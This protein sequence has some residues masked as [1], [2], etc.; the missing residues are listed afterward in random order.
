MACFRWLTAA[1]TL[2]FQRDISS[3]AANLDIITAWLSLSQEGTTL[4]DM[5][6]VGQTQRF[7]TCRFNPI[8][9]QISVEVMGQL[10]FL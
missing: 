1:L 6:Q 3:H 2:L 7:R 5:P 9:K 4:A 8:G 10:I